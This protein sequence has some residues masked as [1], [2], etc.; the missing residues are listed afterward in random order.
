[1]TESPAPTMFR[2]RITHLV[3]IFAKLKLR[4]VRAAGSS[5]RSWTR[6]SHVPLLLRAC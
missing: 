3:R 4:Q 5:Q 1:M 6:P 2:A